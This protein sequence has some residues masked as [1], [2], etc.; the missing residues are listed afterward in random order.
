VL[1]TVP[2]LSNEDSATAVGLDVV[3]IEQ[4]ALAEDFFEPGNFLR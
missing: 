4:L 3:S 1:A 2:E